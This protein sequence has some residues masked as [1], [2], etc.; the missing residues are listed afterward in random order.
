MLPQTTS[1][2]SHGTLATSAMTRAVSTER[3]RAEIADAL[4]DL[5]LAVRPQDAEA[6]DADRSGGVGAGAA[7]DAAHLAAGALAAV[8]LAR[9]PAEQLGALVE[10]SLT[11]QL[12]SL[13]RGRPGGVFGGTRPNSAWPSGAFSLRIAT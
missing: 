4:V 9:F 3:V 5:Q 6:V 7:A 8:G 2:F 10:A 1:Q 13:L 12:V 11:K